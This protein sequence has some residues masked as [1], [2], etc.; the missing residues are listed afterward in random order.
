MPAINSPFVL[1]NYQETMLMNRVIF[2]VVT[3]VCIVCLADQSNAG[4]IAH[5][6]FDSNFTD[7]SA[8]GN[9]L[10]ISAGNPAITSTVDE[11]KF[12]NGAVDFISTTSNQDHL[13]LNSAIDFV[14]ADA[15][16]VSFWGRR[17]PGTDAKSGMILGNLTGRD[18]IWTVDSGAAVSGGGLRFR[19][20]GSN[21]YDYEDIDD[22]QVYHHWVVIADGSGSV[23]SYRDNVSLGTKTAVT[24]FGITH[25]GQA[26]S[27]AI[28]SYNGQIDELY[29]FDNAIGPDVV[30]SLFTSN[31]VPEPSTLLL[32]VAAL[33]SGLLTH[34]RRW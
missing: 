15:W 5:Y 26:Y 16:S 18:F 3:T 29:I 19:N 23:A 32:A 25:V 20:S 33:C 8:S 4:V 30:A 12:G 10:T 13:I 27:T 7:S 24:S 22:D 34:R 1:H 31:Q 6:T 9:D 17:R 2:L 14:A 21:S 11:W 28:Q